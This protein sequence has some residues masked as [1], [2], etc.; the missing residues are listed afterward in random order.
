MGARNRASAVHPAQ[1]RRRVKD[2]AD[3]AQ[4]SL[5]SRQ[6]PP[7]SKRRHLREGIISENSQSDIH[8]SSAQLPP[9]VEMTRNVRSTN[10]R[11]TPKPSKK[12]WSSRSSS[13][14]R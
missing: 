14:S 3:P 2:A 6:P 13:D 10:V 11:L 1:A 7:L 5:S 4:Q 12:K 8:T 9:R